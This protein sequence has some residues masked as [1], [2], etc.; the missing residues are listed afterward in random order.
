MF[1]LFLHF[2]EETQP[3]HK[4]FRR[5]KAP[6]KGECGHGILGEIFVFGCLFEGGEGSG[7]GVDVTLLRTTRFQ[8]EL[9]RPAEVSMHHFI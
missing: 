6:K 8:E 1:A 2:K 7:S 3:E 5:L 4:E 9:A